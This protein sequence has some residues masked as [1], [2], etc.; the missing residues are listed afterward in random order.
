MQ[1]EEEKNMPVAETQAYAANAMQVE[2]RK[3][4][5]EAKS[6]ILPIALNHMT[7]TEEPYLD[8]E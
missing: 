1:N 6:G 2:E 7:I 5:F 3:H 8:R 4:N